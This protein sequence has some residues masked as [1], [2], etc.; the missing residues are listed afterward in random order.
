MLYVEIA[1]AAS[2]GHSQMTEL[3]IRQA[4]S[5]RTNFA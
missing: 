1:Y 3:D 2:Y 5:V 4:D